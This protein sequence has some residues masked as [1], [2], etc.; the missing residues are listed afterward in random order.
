MSML[1][2]SGLALPGKVEDQFVLAAAPSRLA[3]LSLARKC[4]HV[5][6]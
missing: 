2:Q 6:R 5:G 4:A 3:S 1:G